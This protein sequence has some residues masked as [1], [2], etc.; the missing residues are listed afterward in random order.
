MATKK[1]TAEAAAEAV[2]EPK[3][4]EEV[5]QPQEATEVAQTAPEAP[6]S[7][8]GGIDIKDTPLGNVEGDL[9]V[10]NADIGL[11]LREGP[12]KSFPVAELLEDGSVLVVLALPY[13]TEVEGWAL[14][15][16]GQRTG[17]VDISYLRELEE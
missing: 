11:N 5:S 6:E 13:G 12:A 7:D 2:Q 4:T 15:H 1:K 14:V 3:E 17:W 8:P 16:T 9:V 10:V